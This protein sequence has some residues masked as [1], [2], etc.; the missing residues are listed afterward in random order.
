MAE[1][2]KVFNFI[3]GLKPWSCYEV[4]RKKTKT[5]EEDF[6]T[7]DRLIEHYDEGTKKKKKPEKAKEKTPKEE[8]SRLNTKLKMRKPLNS[9]IFLDILC[10]HH[11]TQ[12][13]Y[14][15]RSKKA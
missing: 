11:Y 15:R 7:V 9:C 6:A 3:L 5:L 4:K 8:T 2:D 12:E 13:P 10:S 14:P 1:K